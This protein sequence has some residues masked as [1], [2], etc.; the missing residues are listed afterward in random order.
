MRLLTSRFGEV[1]ID[2]ESTYIFSHGLPG[3]EEL[4]QFAFL[5]I[6]EDSHFLFMQ[7]VD[8]GDL[9]FIVTNPFEFFSDYE[10]D[11]SEAVRDELQ[12]VK[13]TDVIVLS[14]VSVQDHIQEATV[15][16]LA[17]I[18]INIKHKLARQIILHGSPYSIKH[19][20]FPNNH[21]E[22]SQPGKE[23]STC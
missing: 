18:I 9:A 12:I 5:P 17:P 22:D 15:N 8:Q 2:K 3:F 19:K 13:D 21:K 10:F 16:L 23:S 7:S 4:Q 14:M 6:Q 1:E 11:L 20:L